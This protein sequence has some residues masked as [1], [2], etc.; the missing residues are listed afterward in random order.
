VEGFV[1]LGTYQFANT[2][3]SDITTLQYATYQPS[4]NP[5]TGIVVGILQFGIDFFGSNDFFQGRLIFDPAANGETVSQDTWQTWDA[6]NGG[7]AEWFY[8]GPTGVWPDTGFPGT[9]DTDPMTWAQIVA[10]Y[11]AARI[12]F[13]DPVLAIEIAGDISDP[14]TEA[15]NSVTFGTTSG[16]TR[17]VFEPA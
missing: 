12:N 2:P 3:L 1:A 14:F 8:F 15:I 11:P 7:I 6:I 13:N 5:N 17:Y 4:S 16:T 9:P 10:K